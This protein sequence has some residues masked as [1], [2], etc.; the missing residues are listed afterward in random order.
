MS[1]RNEEASEKARTSMREAFR[2][3]NLMPANVSLAT[4][5]IVRQ[6]EVSLTAKRKANVWARIKTYQ[7]V[8]WKP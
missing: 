7:G 4:W 8:A 2:K 3:I 1:D 6:R 5:R